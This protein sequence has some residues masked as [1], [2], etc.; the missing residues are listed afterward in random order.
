MLVFFNWPKSTRN[1]NR[2][3]KFSLCTEYLKIWTAHAR[4]L[5]EFQ[6]IWVINWCL[7]FI[8][9]TGKSFLSHTYTT[10]CTE[11]GTKNLLNAH[12][13]NVKHI[14]SAAIERSTIDV[15]LCALRCTR[16]AALQRKESV[17]KRMSEVPVYCKVKWI[18]NISHIIFL[19]WFV[20]NKIFPLAYS[21]KKKDK[22]MLR[23]K[24]K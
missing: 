15:L 21:K 20:G 9:K 4:S 8:K 13:S 7:D 6:K 17:L 18:V 14:M 2:W 1:V 16:A 23:A 3:W 10:R 11:H 12:S 19:C 5:N 24:T 22:F